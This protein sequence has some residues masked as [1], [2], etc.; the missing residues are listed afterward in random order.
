MAYDRRRCFN[1]MANRHEVCITWV[2]AYRYIPGNCKVDDLVRRGTTIE[3]SDEFCTLGI[4]LSTFRLTI[5][6]TIVNLVNSRWVAPDEVR[7]A[8][9]I[10]P[11]LDR[12]CSSL[13]SELLRGYYVA[14]GTHARC[15][16]LKQLANDFCRSCGD[17]EE[18]K[19]ILHLLCPYQEELDALSCIDIGSLS[20]FIGSSKWFKEKGG[21]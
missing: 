10:W 8:W 19:T 14:L 18:D 2:P 20:R 11:R 17:E 7:T 3:L 13:F 9:K 5:D 1:E 12:R 15:I 6:N 21:M 4:P 16:G